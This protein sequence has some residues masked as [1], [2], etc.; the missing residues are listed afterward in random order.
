MKYTLPAFIITALF[1]CFFKMN[2]IEQ[3]VEVHNTSLQDV[4]ITMEALSERV[5]Q[6]E[7]AVK[8]LSNSV[9]K[10]VERLNK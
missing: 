5:K 6:N 4:S 9:D 3:Q 2:R 8:S 7:Q 10:L 1:I